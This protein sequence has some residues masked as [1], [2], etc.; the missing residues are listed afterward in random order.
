MKQVLAV[1][2]A[3]GLLAMAVT[4]GC[5]QMPTET[6]NVVDLRPRIS[7]R[8]ESDRAREATVLVDKLEMGRVGDYIDGW[9]ELRLLP[10]RHL[11]QVVADDT[12]LLE[13]DVYLG[14]GVGRTFLVQ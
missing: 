7:F 6:Q 14:D 10:G 5:V 2:L 13:E 3:A 12:I 8:T 9:K 11:I 4:P 1:T